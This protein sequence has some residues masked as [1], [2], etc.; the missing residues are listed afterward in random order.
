[1]TVSATAPLVE[2][3]GERSAD[4]LGFLFESGIPPNRIVIELTEH[5]RIADPRA[6]ETWV[7]ALRGA[8]TA[9][10]LD[11]FGDGHSSLRLWAE[12]VP[13]FVKIDKYFVRGLQGDTARFQCVKA[14]AKLSQEF[15]TRLVA[16]GIEEEADFRTIRDLGIEFGQGFL[17]GAPLPE[18]SH[19]PAENIILLLASDEI[20][21]YP[22]TV[23][24]PIQRH[25]L[26]PLVVP[27]PTLAST[28]SNDAA[29]QLFNDSPDLHAMAVIDLDSPVGIVN[30]RAFMERYAQPYYRELFGKR[31]CVSLMNDRPFVI[32]RN[33]SIETLTEVLT[34]QDQRAK[35]AL[36]VAAARAIWA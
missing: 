14:L 2:R 33:A 11:D 25:T 21:V 35:L 24:A 9:F 8:G 18:P 10:A 31:S 23:K 27:A 34:E 12:L 29:V 4:A 36:V 30:R 20:A 1:M 7:L 16:E 13:E 3:L 5:E 22:E 17:I 26:A 28:I 19:A 15:G 6:L 32:D